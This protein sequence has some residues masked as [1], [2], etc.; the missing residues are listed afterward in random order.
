MKN[1]INFLRSKIFLINLGLALA[2]VITLCFLT[3]QWLKS[4]THHGE[5]VEV[6]DLSKLSVMEMRD[7][8]E[9]ACRQSCPYWQDGR[10]PSAPT[11]AIFTG[12]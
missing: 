8:I 9:A 4:S 3:L 12:V 11:T 1:F 2:A 6:P 10:T 7:V 5:F